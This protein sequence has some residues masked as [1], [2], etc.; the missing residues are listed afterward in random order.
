VILLAALGLQ[1]RD[2]AVEVGLDRRQVALWRQRFLYGG[3]VRA[4]LPH[5]S[6]CL[7]RPCCS[8][9]STRCTAA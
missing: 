8:Q 2:L 9:H 4:T 1:N 7:V 6:K 3:I 5:D